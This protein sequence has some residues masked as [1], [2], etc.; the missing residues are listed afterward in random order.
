MTVDF[1]VVVS[2]FVRISDEILV[3]YLD[4]FPT[5]YCCI[6][7]LFLPLLCQIDVRVDDGSGEGNL[8]G[9]SIAF[10]KFGVRES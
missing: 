9:G 8:L 3:A 2:L 7:V 1:V 5:A 10:H 6:D 4:Y